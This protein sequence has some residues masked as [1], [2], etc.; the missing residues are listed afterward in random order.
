MRKILLHIFTAALAVLVVSCKQEDIPTY[1]TADSAVRFQHKSEQFSLRGKTDSQIDL[2]IKLDLFGP[3]CDYDRKIKVE[4][5]D[6]SYNNAVIGTDF[7]IMDAVVPAGELFGKITLKVKMV[8]MDRPTMT[9]TLAIRSGDD[10]KYLVSEGSVCRVIWSD[11]YMRPSNTFAWQS[12]YYFFGPCYSKAYHKLLIEVLGDEIEHSGYS[13]GA[14]NDPDTDYHV[15]T[16]WYAQA[17]QFYDFVKSH[18]AAHPDDPY[19]HSD[20]FESYTSY[21]TPVGQGIKPDKIPT[22]LSTFNSN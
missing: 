21:L 13:N 17:G 6:S 18:D 19:M 11:E 22:I 4:V 8:S 5:A 16:W 2:T 10:F 1:D 20:D 9:T 12:W 14:K 15:M 3:A 7:E